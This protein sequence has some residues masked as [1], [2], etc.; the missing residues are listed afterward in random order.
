M[1]AIHDMYLQIPSTGI[2]DVALRSYIVG[3]YDDP[4]SVSDLAKLFL[5]GKEQIDRILFTSI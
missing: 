3:T 2:D 1:S 5:T 4:D